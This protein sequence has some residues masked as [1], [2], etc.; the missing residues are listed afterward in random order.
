MIK[1]VIISFVLISVWLGLS[2]Y[3]LSAQ[4]DLPAE[5]VQVIKNF[6][7]RLADANKMGFDPIIP[8]PDTASLRYEY[9]VSPKVLDVNYE[10]PVLR[11][12]GIKSEKLPPG[13][14][15][16]LKAGYGYPNNPFGQFGYQYVNDQ[17]NL[18]I[19]ANHLSSNNS[20]EKE[21][22]RFMDNDIRLNGSY[23]TDNEIAFEGSAGFSLDDYYYYGYESD[24]TTTFLPEEVRRRFNTQ[25]LDFKIF[26]G[27]DNDASFNYFAG[28]DAYRHADNQ[29]AR[30]TGFLIHLGASKWIADKHPLSL[31]LKTDFTN[32]K[33]TATYNLHNFNLLPSFTFHSEKF[34][35]KAGVNIASHDDEY[36]FFP[37]A[38]LALAISGNQFILF[39]GA[40]GDLQKNTFLSL[41]TVNPFLDNRINSIRNT[42][43]INYYGGIKGNVSMFQY[44]FLGVYKS[45]RQLALYQP[46]LEEP[47]NKYDVIYDDGDIIYAKGTLIVR[48]SERVEAFLGIQKNIFNLDNQEE[49]WGLPSLEANIGINYLALENKLKVSLETFLMDKIPHF[50]DEEQLIESNTLFDINVSAD[51]FISEK[52]GVFAQL[53]NLASV[54]YRRWHQ[55]PTIG[56][57][58]IGGIM[59]RF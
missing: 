59:L 51:Y 31:E 24:S 11:P 35:L 57:N 4:D 27:E 3:A 25:D 17:L 15:G 29:A 45:V 43:L 26:N 5:E 13:Y 28:F 47:I 49:H 14:N 8:A 7:A 20:K 37:N 36:Y 9:N 48:P 38:E 46:K 12:I 1:Q 54:Q 39:G 42:E 10:A 19:M 32:Y 52:F 58:A 40:E 30:E 34:R 50:T 21:N 6:Q 33:D 2:S 23:F 56:I 16:F 44:E 41:T 22:Q 18:G 55:Y 53:N